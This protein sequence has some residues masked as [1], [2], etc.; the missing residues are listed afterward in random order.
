[1]Q[2]RSEQ[3]RILIVDDHQLVRETLCGLLD[4]YPMIEVVG[5]S[6]DAEAGLQQ[7]R[8]LRPNVVLMDIDMPGGCPFEVAATIDREFPDIR[9]VFLSAHWPDGFIAQALEARAAGYLAKTTRPQ[10][11]IRAILQI[12]AG[13]FVVSP[14]IRVRMVEAGIRRRASAQ[15]PTRLD[16]LSDRERELLIM[17]GSGLSRADISKNM[18]LTVSTVN[19]HM[20]S[21][22]RKLDLHGSL[23][24][25]RFAIREGLVRP[26]WSGEDRPAGM[27]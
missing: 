11:L 15:K 8:A 12:A 17:L 23:E 10:E 19:V 14:A 5:Q 13:Q 27:C 2:E 9:V 18:N 3:V 21:I 16:M 24:L 7:C 25:T 4:H 26:D 1:M 22:M 20:T 6:A